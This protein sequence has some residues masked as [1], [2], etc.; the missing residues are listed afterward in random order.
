MVRPELTAFPAMNIVAF[1]KFARYTPAG[2][3]SLTL[4]E[5]GERLCHVNSRD[6]LRWVK[7]SPVN[8]TFGWYVERLIEKGKNLNISTMKK[9]RAES[10]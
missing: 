5:S 10:D 7:T 1:A 2:C 6:L 9:L 8:L 3:I 4:G